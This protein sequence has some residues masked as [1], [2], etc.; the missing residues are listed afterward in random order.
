[1]IYHWLTDYFVNQM[2]DDEVAEN[3]ESKQQQE[4]E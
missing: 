3:E 1:M 4:E 2:R